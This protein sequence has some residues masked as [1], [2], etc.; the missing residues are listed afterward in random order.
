MSDYNF[1]DINRMYFDVLK[2][3]GN[4]GAGNATTAIS[5][6]LGLRLNMEVPQVKLLS[7]Q[8]LG[9]AVSAEEDTIAGIYLELHNDLE[10]SM[11][12]LLKM[13][14]AHYLVNRLMGRAESYEE[15]FDEMDLSALKEIGNIIMGSYLSALSSMTQMMIAPS[16]PFLAIDMAAAILSVPAIQ[17]GQYGDDALLIETEFGDDVKLN[18][19]FI[20]LPE[21]DSYGKILSALGIEM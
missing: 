17:F 12:F 19:F 1:E 7:F 20:L 10:G 8:E 11:M 14:S 2:E 3:I 16:V 18:G 4:I 5:D 6:M 21:P 9:S 15:P 13:D